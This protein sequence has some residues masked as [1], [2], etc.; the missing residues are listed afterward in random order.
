MKYYVIS[1]SDY[2]I[3]ISLYNYKTGEFCFRSISKSILV[4]FNAAVKKVKSEFTKHSNKLC[5]NKHVNGDLNWIKSVIK[6][7]CDGDPWFVS[8]SGEINNTDSD[9]NSLIDK[10]LSKNKQ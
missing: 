9:V 10:Y 3:A 2:N 6:E 5:I 1:N 7:I 8:S 4:S